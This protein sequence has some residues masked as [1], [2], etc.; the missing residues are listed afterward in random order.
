MAILF[1][2]SRCD[3]GVPVN[4]ANVSRFPPIAAYAEASNRQTSKLNLPPRCQVMSVNSAVDRVQQN[5]EVCIRLRNDDGKNLHRN[6][7]ATV[8]PVLAITTGGFDIRDVP[9]LIK[10]SGVTESST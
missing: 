5:V 7:S 2:S 1:N 9:P 6:R 4:E 3:G 8:N 10:I